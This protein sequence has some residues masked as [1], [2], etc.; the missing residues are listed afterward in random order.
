MNTINSAILL[1]EAIFELEIKKKEQ[2]QTI[3]EQFHVIKENLR[4]ANIIRNTFEEVAASPKLRINLMG[5][6]VGLGAAYFSR[7]L[8]V[9]KSASTFRNILGSV[10]Q[11]GISAVVASKPGVL[12]SI[13]QTIAKRVFTKKNSYEPTSHQRN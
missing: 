12:Q 9:G 11:L 6:L 5:A 1:K 8:V 3:K 10:L 7:K 4:P 13:G 2:G